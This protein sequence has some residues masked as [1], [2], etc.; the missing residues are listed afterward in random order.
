LALALLAG[1]QSNA[2]GLGLLPPLLFAI[3]PH[4]AVLAGIVQQRLPDQLAPRGVPVFTALQE[5]AVPLAVLAAAAA[6]LVSLSPFWVVGAIAWLGS[7]LVDW[8]LGDGQRDAWGA[9]RRGRSVL[10]GGI[11]GRALGDVR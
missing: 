1:Q 7:I 8:G 2:H 5:P 3:V 6:G 9:F 10:A 4:L 11:A